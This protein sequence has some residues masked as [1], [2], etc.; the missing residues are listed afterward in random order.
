MPSQEQQSEPL[1]GVGI[2]LRSQHYQ[3]ILK[4][5]PD[6][7]WF[8]AL[9]DNYMNDGGLPLYYLE[10]IRQHYPITFHG[11][12]M[13][14]GATD[15][16]NEE[17]LT[18][19]KGLIARFE[20]V[21]V[22]DHLCWSSHSGLYANDLL[23]M[24]YTQEA[25]RHI[26][27]RILRVQDFLGRR[28][29]IENVSSYVSYTQSVMEEVDFLTEVVGQAD[30]DLLCDVNNIY[31]SAK[32]H[33]YDPLVYLSKLPADRIKEFHLAGYED[34]GT[35]LLDTHGAR[36]HEPVWALYQEALK[37]FGPI[38]TLIEWDTDIPDFDV[39]VQE[40]SRAKD[41]MSEHGG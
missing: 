10:Q 22:S 40:Q 11:V 5:S 30:C 24:P 3:D 17:Y 29:L 6:I 2:G 39:L 27:E 18:R 15:P 20:P 4:H 23:P 41:F 25:V 37:R 12:G 9:S 8:E 35:H 1:T 36:V 21:Y 38:P 7:P 28:I 34:M 26:A 32:N 13:S 16:L 19:L 33:H 31:V 14:L